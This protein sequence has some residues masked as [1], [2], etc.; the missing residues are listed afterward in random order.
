MRAGDLDDDDGIPDD[1]PPGDPNVGGNGLGDPDIDAD[2]PQDGMWAAAVPGP[3]ALGAETGLMCRNVQ[4][5]DGDV[6]I[7]DGCGP[8]VGEDPPE[9]YVGVTINNDFDGFANED[10]LS[11]SSAASGCAPGLARRDG[12][13]QYPQLFDVEPSVGG[14]AEPLGRTDAP[15]EA[16]G[17]SGTAFPDAVPVAAAV[18]AA[19]VGLGAGGWYARR[20]T[21]R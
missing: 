4:D 19:I 6:A 2:A 16:A 18:A 10:G 8:K 7:N 3:G 15:A 1:G 14:I 9:F 21:L 20:R 12:C 11:F 5:D 17:G 13:R